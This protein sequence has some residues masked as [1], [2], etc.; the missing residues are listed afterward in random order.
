MP[1][2]VVATSGDAVRGVDDADQG[3]L[4]GGQPLGKPRSEAPDC[5][6]ETSTAG[7][8]R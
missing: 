3:V 2:N 7:M 1:P 8:G 5:R 6:R 4:L